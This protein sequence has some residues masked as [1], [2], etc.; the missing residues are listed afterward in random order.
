MPDSE[1]ITVKK[2]DVMWNLCEN[3]LIKQINNHEIEILNIIEKH[4]NKEI[5]IDKAKEDLLK[6]KEESYSEMLRDLIDEIAALKSFDE[7]EELLKDWEK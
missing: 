3:F 2:G 6:I 5:N 7:I 4:K 1:K